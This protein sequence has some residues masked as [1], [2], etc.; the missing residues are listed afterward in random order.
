LCLRPAAS[1]PRPSQE[2]EL[3][4]RILLDGGHRALLALTT[5]WYHE[6]M[7]PEQALELR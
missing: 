7:L 3:G 5:Q 4:A 6:E 2:G 1:P